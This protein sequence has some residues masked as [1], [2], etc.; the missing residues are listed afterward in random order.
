MSQSVQNSNM[1]VENNPNQGPS[2]APASSSD[3]Q[4]PSTKHLFAFTTRQDCGPLVAGITAAVLTGALKASLAILLG[5]I[6]SVVTDFGAGRLSGPETRDHVSSWCVILAVIGAAAWLINFAFM[7]LWTVFSDIQVRHIR[8]KIFRGLLDKEMEWFDSQEEGLASLLVRLQTQTRELEIATSMALGLLT[9]E[10]TAALANLAVALYLS[11]K[12]TLVLL[13]TAPVSFGINTFLGRKFTPALIIQRRELARATKYATSAITAIDLVKVFN[14][15]DHEVWQYSVAIRRSMGHYLVQV[16]ASAYQRGFLK[17]SLDVMFV[18]G[19]YYGAVLVSQGLSAGNVMATFYAALAALQAVNAFA[20]MYPLLMKGKL[21]GQALKIVT[22][23]AQGGRG[24]K[25]MMGVHRPEKCVGVV[26]ME[27]VSFAYPSNPTKTVLHKSSFYFQA[28]D[29]SFIVGKSGSGKSTLSNLL[30]RFYEPLSGEIWIDGL[31]LRTL[32]LNWIR[33]NITLIQQISVLFNDTF[34][35]NVALGHQHPYRASLEEVKAACETA[36]LQSTISGLPSGLDTFVGAGGHNMSGGQKQRLALARAKLRDPP[37]LILD[38]VTSGLDP[39]SR[40]LVMEAIRQWRHGKT[41]IIITHEVAQIKDEDYVYVMDDGSIVQNGYSRDLRQQNHGLFAQLLSSSTR[42]PSAVAI[43]ENESDVEIEGDLLAGRPSD[44][45][46][47]SRPSSDVS[48]YRNPISRFLMPDG[49][50]IVSL[51]PQRM[52]MGLWTPNFHAQ[53]LFNE[54]LWDADKNR[55]EPQP[56]PVVGGVAYLQTSRA[57]TPTSAFP[58]SPRSIAHGARNKSMIMLQELGETVRDNRRGS[59]SRERRHVPQIVTPAADRDLSGDEESERHKKEGVDR[60]KTKKPTVTLWAIY[61]TVWPSLGGKERF[62]VT[63]GLVSCMVVAG[64]VPAFSYVFANLLAVLYQSGNRAAAGQKW[65]LLLLLIASSS[66]LATFTMHYLLEWVAQ[67]WVN[68]LRLQA[69]NRILRQPKPFFDKSKNSPSRINEC[70]ER[71]AEEMR[72]L[73]GRFAPQVLVIVIMIV[74]SIIWAMA[75]SWKLTLVSLACAPVLMGSSKGQAYVSH[76]WEMR[77]TK[78]AEET[79][80]VVTETFINIRVVRALTLE[81]YFAKKHGRLAEK[82]FRLGIQKAIWS[83]GLYGFSQ[84]MVFIMLALIFFYAAVLL[85]TDPDTDTRNIL[86]VINLLAL[87]LNTA[88]SMLNSIPGITTAQATAGRLLYYANLPLHSSHET[89]GRKTLIDPFPIRMEKLSFTYPTKRNSPALRGVTLQ[90]NPGTSTAIVGPSGCGKSTIA[91]ILLGLYLPD[92]FESNVQSLTFASVPLAEIV[93]STLRA[94]IGY[95]PQAPFLFPSTIAGNIAYGLAED[96]PLRHIDNLSQAAKEAGIHD[97]IHSLSDGY[98]T[99]VGDGGQT[100]SGGQAQRV[101]IARALARRPTIL[102]LDEPTSALDAESAEGVRR[103]IQALMQ[104]ARASVYGG[105]GGSVGQASM[106]NHGQNQKA[107]LAVIMVTHSKEM[108]RTVD[109]IVVVDQGCV[110]EEGAY[111]ELY[112]KRGKFAELVSEGIWMGAPLLETP[113]RHRRRRGGGGK[114]SQSSSYHRGGDPGP[115]GR[116]S[117]LPFRKSN[118]TPGS[119][120]D[121]PIK[122]HWVGVRDVEWGRGSVGP[123]TGAMSPI[124]SPFSLHSRRRERR[125]EGEE[126]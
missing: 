91:S 34:F 111:E 5:K 20:T 126:V 63:V 28:G 115:G 71:N 98:D 123:T 58:G 118:T 113:D 32:D 89:R 17:L 18:L 97:F 80:A 76:K 85:S 103:T 3:L 42:K 66:A 121:V 64:G 84:A 13:A 43:Y 54:S 56:S 6:F 122:S 81:G 60:P 101:C 61:K 59:F 105:R 112:R 23:E 104:N 52:T 12:L 48:L 69:L 87:G 53:Q 109:R 19:F 77:C 49:V 37:I 25:R 10:T 44:V 38:E 74:T 78:A 83:S 108:M 117:D 99:I 82:T 55:L 26:K 100:L 107:Q 116:D 40:T 30:V 70:M 79:T 31:S 120:E 14:G 4:K 75:I 47:L 94:H 57:D 2:N 24:V 119:P 27:D 51:M 36:L 62:F 73:V 88:S 65:S 95:V 125:E 93:L 41:T 33:S 45:T 15:L 7:L 102:V 110:V 8:Y 16:R 90:F 67:A 46:D 86:Q 106:R 96:S 114:E 68:Q 72:S 22:S 39:T 35:V 21:A 50:S 92:N 124:A 9:A 1:T 11:W 29:I